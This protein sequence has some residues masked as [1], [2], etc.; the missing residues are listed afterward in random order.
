MKSFNL[1]FSRNVLGRFYSTKYDVIVVGGGHAG[2]E[3]CHAAA[4][5]K[6]RTLLITH[7][8]TTI[9]EMS[10]NPSF[11]GIGKGHLMREIDALDGVCCRICDKSGVQY[12][13]LNRRKGPA[14][15][16]LRAQIDRELYRKFMQ[17]EIFNTPN[18]SIITGSVENLNIERGTNDEIRC[19]GVILADGKKYESN[20]IVLTT[21]TFLR[22]NINIGLEAR[23]A[24]RIGDEPSI[25]LAD[26]LQ[27]LHFKI[28]RLRTGTPPRLERS[29][30]NFKNL[31]YITG[32]DPSIPF[33]F[34]N[35][36]VWIKPEDQLKCYM[37]MTNKTVEDICLSSLK[38]NRHVREEVQGPRYCPSIES[39]AIKFRGKEHLVWLE[40]ESLNSSVIYPGG[41]SCTMPAEMQER[42]IHA[43]PGLENAVILRPG[44]GVEYEFIDPRELTAALETKK[45][46]GLFFAGQINGTTGYEEA[47]AQ[48]ILAGINAAAKALGKPEFLISRT[49]G[50]I[51]VLVD[52]LTTLGTNEPYRMFTARSEFRLYLRPDNADIRL[53]RRGYQI[54]CVSEERYRHFCD[55]EKEFFEGLDILSSVEKSVYKW[56]EGLGLCVSRCTGN[57]KAIDVFS[58][59]LTITVDQ[60]MKAYPEEFAHV[61]KRASVQN[62]LAVEGMYRREMTKQMEKIK[63]LQEEESF[64]IPLEIDYNLKSLSLRF[65]EIEKLS[66]VRPQTVSS[67]MNVVYLII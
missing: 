8:T 14:V 35:E 43:I 11:G 7:K 9:G 51:G 57:S 17:E 4:R 34:L 48:G 44:Y 18:L 56:R 46:N 20:C 19:C 36:S 3:A 32:D 15:W 54:G 62:K 1:A 55:V 22:A 59:G 66:M 37:T 28:G 38:V 12:K 5:M 27:K 40:P 47:A 63:Q 67:F 39:K 41:L 50:Y 23:P 52:D 26:T 25:G 42:M 61:T 53:T 2:V 33:S 10:C 64:K 24:G 13:V 45:I 16:G 21:G 31:N 6:A 58:M 65:E 60:L 49:E 30:I 29:S